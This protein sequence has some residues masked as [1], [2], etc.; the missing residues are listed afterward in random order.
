MRARSSRERMYATKLHLIRDHKDLWIALRGGE[1]PSPDSLQ[2]TI[3]ACSMEECQK[4]A[5]R[6][7][8]G[9]P[10][11]PGLPGE[12]PGPLR[13]PGHP[14]STRISPPYRAISIRI[15]S[16]SPWPL[17]RSLARIGKCLFRTILDAV[18]YCNG[19]DSISSRLDYHHHLNTRSALHDVTNQSEDLRQEVV[20]DDLQPPS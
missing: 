20:S 16:P 13:V 4:S 10:S 2:V 14:S 5:S 8:M 15:S 6:V 1:I 9:M 3:T 12:L 18:P 11:S 19:D 7:G 17:H